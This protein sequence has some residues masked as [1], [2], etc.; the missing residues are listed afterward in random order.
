MEGNEKKRR[1]QP[2]TNPGGESIP[3]R[4]MQRR[5]T[6]R[7]HRVAASIGFCAKRT[8]PTCSESSYRLREARAGVGGRVRSGRSTASHDPARRHHRARSNSIYRYLY[9]KIYKLLLLLILL[10]SNQRAGR[11]RPPFAM[12][13][14]SSA[15]SRLS[16]PDEP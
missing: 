11:R 6:Q 15:R 12:P 13:F 14:I 4:K 1:Y 7:I 3:K 5:C 2:N 10:V 9:Q 8:P 16:K